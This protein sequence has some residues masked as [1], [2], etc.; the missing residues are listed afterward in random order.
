MFMV[1]MLSMKTICRGW[2]LDL[3]TIVNYSF[4]GVAMSRI[5]QVFMHWKVM[6]EWLD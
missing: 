2:V 4:G 5:H 3:P 6:M 1:E